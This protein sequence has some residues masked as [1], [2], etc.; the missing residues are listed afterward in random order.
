[1]YKNIQSRNTWSAKIIGWKCLSIQEWCAIKLIPYQHLFMSQ[2]QFPDFF[3]HILPFVLDSANNLRLH[4]NQKTIVF[5]YSWQALVV[6]LIY[7]L[8]HDLSLC[9]YG[10]PTDLSIT[11]RGRCWQVSGSHLY[12]PHM[13][14]FLKS[15]VY[16]PAPRSPISFKSH[17]SLEFYIIPNV[18]FSLEKNNWYK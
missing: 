18:L 11:S 2:K 8:L 1:M 13:L 4:E 15:C 6:R 17:V 3:Q 12:C 7:W 9:G 16:P 10:R 5:H 14:T